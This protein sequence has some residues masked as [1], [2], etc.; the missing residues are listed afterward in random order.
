MLGAYSFSATAATALTV[1]TAGTP[2]THYER[3]LHDDSGL[4]TTAGTFA[5]GCH[6]SRPGMGSHRT[7][8]LGTTSTHQAVFAGV[9][10]FPSGGDDALWF[11]SVDPT[12][13]AMSTFKTD[14]SLPSIAKVAYGDLNGDGMSDI[15]RISASRPPLPC[16]A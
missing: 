11:G 4:S 10:Y 9:G 7:A 1:K 5:G 14:L 2:A 12:T 15:V 8:Y 6:D 3:I 13:L 16:G